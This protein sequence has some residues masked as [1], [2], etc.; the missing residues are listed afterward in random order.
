MDGLGTVLERAVVSFTH[1]QAMSHLTP[2]FHEFRTG[3]SSGKSP[4]LRVT[5]VNG[6][7]APD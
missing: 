4:V 5:K 3:T 6:G 2:S 1:R 7:G